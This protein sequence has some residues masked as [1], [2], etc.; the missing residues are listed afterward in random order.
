M[1]RSVRRQVAFVSVF[2]V[3]VALFVTMF[4]MGVVRGSSMEPTYE[5]GQVVLV[6]RRNRFSPPL[7]RSDVILVRHDR[8]VLIK[9]IYR[10]EDEEMTDTFPYTAAMIRHSGLDD[11]YEQQPAIAPV[12]GPPPRLFVP[13]G[14]VV[15]LGDNIRNSEDSRVFGP[16]PMRDILGVV[17][18]SPRP[19]YET[20]NAPFRPSLPPAP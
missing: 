20:G 11:Y 15:V 14:Y 9:R 18:N 8:D 12:N 7:K 10:L 16:V 1:S 5:N 2:L 3:V 4:R 6:Q 17:V 19:P 13:R